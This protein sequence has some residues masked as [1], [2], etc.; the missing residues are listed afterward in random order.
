M[1]DVAALICLAYGAQSYG[2][3]GFF[4]SILAQRHP[5]IPL[6]SAMDRPSETFP[7][8][9][10]STLQSAVT[11]GEEPIVLSPFFP[12]Y[13]PRYTTKSNIHPSLKLR[14]LKLFPTLGILLLQRPKIIKIRTN[15]LKHSFPADLLDERAQLITWSRLQT[16]LEDLEALLASCWRRIVAFQLRRGTGGCGVD[17]FAAEVLAQAVQAAFFEGEGAGS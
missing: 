4:S 8:C 10:K 1:W 12:S 11:T 17:D 16:F 5:K 3:L 7:L 15:L 13:L 9:T 14:V 2:V 6:S